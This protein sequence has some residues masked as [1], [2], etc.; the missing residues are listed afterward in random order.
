[1]KIAGCI[2]G[3]IFLG[4][5]IFYLLVLRPPFRVWDRVEVLSK[6]Q[7]MVSLGGEKPDFPKG[8]GTVMSM[9][10]KDF[11]GLST[12]R[13]VAVKFDDTSPTESAQIYSVAVL[14]YCPVKK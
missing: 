7:T 5:V 11:F 10:I 4:F 1:M 8:C 2:F 13:F 6:Y 9:S 3:V 12:S 14:E